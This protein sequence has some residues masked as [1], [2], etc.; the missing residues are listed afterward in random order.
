MSAASN[1]RQ[2]SSSVSAPGPR[3]WGWRAA[4]VAASA[5]AIVSLGAWA[6]TTGQPAAPASAASEPGMPPG[7][8]GM[9]MGG[10]GHGH[11]HHHGMGGHERRGDRNPGMMPFAGQ[12]LQRLLDDVKATDAQR[13]QIKA[14]A[15]KAQT[16]LKALHEAGSKLHEQGLN[17]WASPKLDAASAEAF[18]QQMLKH[19]NQLSQRM[20]QAMLDVGKV[21]TPEQRATLVKQMREHRMGMVDRMKA[22]MGWGHGGA[23]GGQRGPEGERTPEGKRSPPP[24]PQGASAPAPQAR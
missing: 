2:V 21:L 8:P 12:H 7:G 13:T 1:P 18:R 4:A 11:G 19:H 24:P 9:G 17:L 15:D 22:H 20:T 16:E 23:E 3:K 14:I 6:A 10:H 5:T